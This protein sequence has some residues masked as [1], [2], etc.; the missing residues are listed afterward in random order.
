MF[1]LNL[2]WCTGQDKALWYLLLGRKKKKEIG[3]KMVGKS[4]MRAILREIKQIEEGREG[5][6]EK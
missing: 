5:R 4:E 3:R 6:R 2:A 1:T